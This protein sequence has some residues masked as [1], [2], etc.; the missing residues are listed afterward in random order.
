LLLYA[1]KGH[2]CSLLISNIFCNP[3]FLCLPFASRPFNAQTPFSLFS[4]GDCS[5]FFR[6]GLCL[7]KANFFDL[8]EY[9]LQEFS[10]VSTDLNEMTDFLF[11]L[12]S[13]NSRH[14]QSAHYQV[15]VFSTRPHPGSLTF[16]CP[17]FY[18][19][20]FRTTAPSRSYRFLLPIVQT[21]LLLESFW[22]SPCLLA[23]RLV[24]PSF[25][26][27][28]YSTKISELQYGN[29]TEIHNPKLCKR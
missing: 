23:H 2:F 24:P 6:I 17:L 11:L 8:S 4:S 27:L 10:Q 29:L 5:C 12:L 18:R 7:Q 21:A 20:L 9:V 13:Q 14:Y 25:L 15:T 16:L 19:I 26:H 22:K 28:Y 3:L 1:T